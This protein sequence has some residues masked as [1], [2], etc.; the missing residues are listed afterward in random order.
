MSEQTYSIG[1]LCAEFD[2]TPRT[3]RFYEQRELLTPIRDGQRRIFTQRDRARLM[4]ILRGKRFGFS[5]ENIRQW[6]NLY[7]LGDGG[8]TQ[9]TTWVEHARKQMGELAAQRD[10]LNDAMAEL[11]DLI[12][13]AEAELAGRTAS[14]AAE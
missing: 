11:Q 8:M 4:L 5:L 10:E 9:I 2:V 7:D 12:N 14:K 13:A 3:L 6:L 1:E